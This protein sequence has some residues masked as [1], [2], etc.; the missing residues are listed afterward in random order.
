MPIIMLTNVRSL[1]KKI[2]ELTVI[3]SLRNPSV[4]CITE[5]WLSEEVEDYL[6]AIPGY[7]MFRT[8]RKG[9][10]GGGTAIYVKSH[11]NVQRLEALPQ[12]HLTLILC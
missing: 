5:T 10:R 2:D 8:D 11:L 4:I 9:R 7:R 1:A 12:C 3:S 6:I